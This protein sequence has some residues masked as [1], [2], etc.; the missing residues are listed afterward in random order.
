VAVDSELLSFIQPFDMGIPPTGCIFMMLII[1]YCR[2]RWYKNSVLR[3]VDLEERKSEIERW[4]ERLYIYICHQLGKTKFLSRKGN[5]YLTEIYPEVFLI[6]MASFVYTT[7]ESDETIRCNMYSAIIIFSIC[8]IC[9]NLFAN[10]IFGNEI[11]PKNTIKSKIFISPFVSSLF[12]GVIFSAPPHLQ[13]QVK[14]GETEI[15]S[16]R[17]HVMPNLIIGQDGD[18]RILIRL[19]GSKFVKCLRNRKNPESPSE[20]L[21]M[22]SGSLRFSTS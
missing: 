11:N 6:M 17:A 12:L 18:S 19:D 20:K 21:S 22:I 3:F 10:Y 15:F 8:F 9:M 1:F 13:C 2:Y 5:Y 4:D 14:E 7:K 16:G